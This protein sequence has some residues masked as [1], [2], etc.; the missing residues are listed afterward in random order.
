MEKWTHQGHP[1]Q[2]RKHSC[3]QR[4]SHQSQRALGSETG[5]ET[6]GQR[7]IKTSMIRGRSTYSSGRGRRD[8]RQRSSPCYCRSG[9]AGCS[10]QRAKLGAR[11]VK[12]TER[13]EGPTTRTIIE[14][15]VPIALEREFCD[16]GGRDALHDSREVSMT[17]VASDA[18]R[19]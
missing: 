7:V 4:R 2:R 17:H 6:S 12:N 18:Q 11:C 1:I 19:G 16:G 3:S 9:E 5:L 15:L 13:Y 14:V 10:H 8:S